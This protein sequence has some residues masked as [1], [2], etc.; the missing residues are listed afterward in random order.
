MMDDVYRSA[1]SVL[2]LRPSDVC[3]PDGTVGRDRRADGC[4]TAY[5]VLL[6]HKPR[7]KDDWQLPQGGVEEGETIEQAA[8]RELKEEAG[9]SGVEVLGKSDSCYKYDFPPSF[10]RFRPD[11]VCGQCIWYVYGLAPSSA[12]VQV[13][14]QEIDG[15]IWALPE[16][17]H[18]YVRRKEYLEFV[19]KLLD[20]AVSAARKVERK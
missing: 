18:L 11:H 5:Q 6:L 10:R 3:S 16:E 17:L 15:H 9:L 20:E 12:A 1:A 2:L 14:G 8:M 13:D 19:T 4:G 7:K